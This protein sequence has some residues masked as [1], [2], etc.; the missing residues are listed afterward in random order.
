MQR[1]GRVLR[2]GEI[3]SDARPDVDRDERVSERV[4]QLAGDTQTLVGQPAPV[5]LLALSSLTLRTLAGGCA[6]RPA[7]ANGVAEYERHDHQQQ[8]QTDPGQLDRP[9]DQHDRDD[10]DDRRERA[11]DQR[12]LAVAEERDGVELDGHE[13]ARRPAG[14]EGSR[15]EDR[16]GLD[17]DQR[18]QRR[19]VRQASGAAVGDGQHVRARGHGAARAK[20]TLDDQR[21]GS[22]K[23]ERDVPGEKAPV[24][25]EAKAT[26]RCAASHRP[27]ERHRRT[28][29]GVA[30]RER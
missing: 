15:A 19:L 2:I 10:G 18:R 17:A 27:S 30:D 20:L 23:G 13:R 24:A 8:P 21:G 29:A 22:G 26:R 11:D 1:G 12:S 14:V 16:S 3:R 6:Q 7:R 9:V 5:L 28:P 4:V 25:H